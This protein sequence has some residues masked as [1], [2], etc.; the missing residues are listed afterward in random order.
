MPGSPQTCRQKTCIAEERR[1]ALNKQRVIEVM[2]APATKDRPKPVPRVKSGKLRI[3]DLL[4]S[5]GFRRR[6]QSYIT[7]GISWLMGWS[8]LTAE[9][10]GRKPDLGCGWLRQN[11]GERMFGFSCPPDLAVIFVGF[12]DRQTTGA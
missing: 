2:N 1:L 6:W 4:P 7:V 3:E 9:S 12:F 10:P 5:V 11:L 8:R